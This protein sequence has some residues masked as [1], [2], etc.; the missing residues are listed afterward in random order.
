MN[1]CYSR[2]NGSL[3]IFSS[4]FFFLMESAATNDYETHGTSWR[5]RA[6]VLV[7][8][9][10]GRFIA[11]VVE[12][13]GRYLSDCEQPHI[14]EFATRGTSNSMVL[15]QKSSN[16][17]N[18]RASLFHPSKIATISAELVET[19]IHTFNITEDSFRF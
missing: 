8:Q 1:I 5:G 18:L 2:D 15:V 6:V 3:G 19:F 12:R 10:A 4:R 17:P 7:R 13:R 11:T 14:A 9:I 16:V